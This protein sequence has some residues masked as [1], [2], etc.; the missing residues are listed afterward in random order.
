MRQAVLSAESTSVPSG[1]P[2]PP[3]PLP[4]AMRGLAAPCGAPHRSRRSCSR[5]RR[6][7][8]RTRARTPYAGHLCVA[9][10][11][12]AAPSAVQELTR[13]R[14]TWRRLDDGA[15][16]RRSGGGVGRAGRAGCLAA[17]GWQWGGAGAQQGAAVM[18]GSPCRP[19]V[20]GPC[21]HSPHT[22]FGLWC[23]H[24]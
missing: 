19:R 21:L 16:R 14:S 10:A 2:P 8:P 23:G 15:A 17:M 6:V 13:A 7:S 3:T 22:V 12:F 24:I 5:P 11:E 1:A 18:P 4:P 20:R 9:P